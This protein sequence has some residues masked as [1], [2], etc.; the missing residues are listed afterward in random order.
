[1]IGYLALAA[2]VAIGGYLIARGLM[3]ATRAQT[4]QWLGGGLGI[5]AAL[6]AA[7][8]AITGRPAVALFPLLAAVAL[9]ILWLGGRS[10]ATAQA[11]RSRVET[12]LLR[13]ELEHATGAVTGDILDGPLLGRRIES[14]AFKELLDL[15]RYCL[16]RDEQSARLVEAFLDRTSPDW[17]DRVRSTGTGSTAPMSESEAL[18]I[19]GLSPGAAPDA[20]RAAHRRKMQQHHPDRGGSAEEAARINR[21]REILLGE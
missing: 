4:M 2:A 17:R 14:L 5:V 19:L 11:Q 6:L 16:S 12:P 15:Y 9:L 7:F 18:A 20:I 3:G 10:R 1:M 8:F 13:L 21:A